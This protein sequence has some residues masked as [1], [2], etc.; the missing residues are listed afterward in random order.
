[1]TSTI[2]L[3]TA[4]QLLDDL[5]EQILAHHE[6]VEDGTR[7]IDYHLLVDMASRAGR[8]HEMVKQA[9]RL[10]ARDAALADRARILVNGLVARSISKADAAEQLRA[11]KQRAR[12]N[13]LARHMVRYAGI[14][15]W[16][17]RRAVLPGI[18]RVAEL[19]YSHF[20][21]EDAGHDC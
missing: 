6:A 8:A 18:L 12:R 21:A 11:I 10:A 17:S 19:D 7:V 13:A 2:K 16:Q 14:I 15:M 1:M 5:V 3:P 9:A 20:A 4:A